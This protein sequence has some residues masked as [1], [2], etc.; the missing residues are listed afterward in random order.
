M[1]KVLII[2]SMNL[3]H[4]AR[5]AMRQSENG[6]T[7]AALRMIR[8]LVNKFEPDIAYFVLEGKPLRR[9]EESGGT[10]KA[11]RESA[12]DS[13]WIQQKQIVETVT[14]YLPVVVAKHPHY[15]ADDVIAYLASS[16]HANDYVT[17]VSTDTD[18]IQLLDKKR[19]TL[20]LFS[21]IKDIM[22][23]APDYN[24]VEWKALR[25]D[26]ADNIPGIPGIGDK[27]AEKLL[28]ETGALKQF[29]VKKPEAKQL[30][31]HNCSMIRF[32]NLEDKKSE[33]QFSIA[34]QDNDSLRESL[35]AFGIQSMTSDKSWG[36]WK[37]T[38]N[39]LWLN[40]RN[41]SY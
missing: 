7:Y 10:Y 8:S 3:I 19:L 9:I 38:F 41:L 18:F 2:D 23:K 25:G 16:R 36:P 34:K 29:F 14:K 5:V 13:F 40:S 1:K 28:T 17:I 30:W 32:E 31:E 20:D 6:T 39:N 21:P 35:R 4:R 27:R 24:Y 33:I 37:N 11:Q 26:G 15:E 22:V 12:D